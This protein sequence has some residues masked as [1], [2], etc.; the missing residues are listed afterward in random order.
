MMLAILK[1]LTRQLKQG[2]RI[3][4]GGLGTALPR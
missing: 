1:N 2:D 3:R 4:I